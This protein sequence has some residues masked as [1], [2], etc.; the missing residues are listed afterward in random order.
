MSAY[1][2][3]DKERQEIDALLRQGYVITGIREDLNGA[4][5]Q[6]TSS[7][8]G[9]NRVELLLLTADSRK[10]VTT[11]IFAGANPAKPLET[12]M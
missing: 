1:A 4:A 10:Y 11:L 7:G 5:V 6:F 9:V 8:P 2:E 12:H 3:F